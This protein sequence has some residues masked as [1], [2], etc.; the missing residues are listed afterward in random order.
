MGFSAESITVERRTGLKYTWVITASQ[1]SLPGMLDGTGT[2]ALNGTTSLG[3]NFLRAG[4]FV[5]SFYLAQ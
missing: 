4:V 1:I 5:S 2:G 3:V